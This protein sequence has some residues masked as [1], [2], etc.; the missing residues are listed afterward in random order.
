[1]KS[2]EFFCFPGLE[3]DVLESLKIEFDR[4]ISFRDK[5]PGIVQVI[6]PLFHEDGDMLDIF[7]DVG[8]DL[9]NGSVRISDYGMT[10]MRLS[11]SY[12]IDTP[13]KQ[14]VLDKILSENG[15]ID[16]NGSLY[17]EAPQGNVYPSLMQFAQ[18]VA[19]VSSMQ[20]FK[21]EVIQSMFYETLNDFIVHTLASYR[22]QQHFVPINDKEELDVDWRFPI[23]G[24][25]IYLYG[26]KDTAKARLAVLSCLEFQKAKLPFRSVIIHQDFETDLGKKDKRRLTNV[27]DKQFATL[28]DFQIEA[29]EYFA[30]ESQVA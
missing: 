19:K 1:M 18:T 5:R 20:A 2:R 15:V 3:M 25:D 6:A 11:Y 24:K 26:V 29:E 8:K 27:A 14:K 17:I 9:G 21:R 22:P 4:H 10:L 13:T 7:L 12:E 28:G 30:R 23:E 16:D